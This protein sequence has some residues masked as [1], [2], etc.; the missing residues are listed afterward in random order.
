MIPATF[1][2][3]LGTRWDDVRQRPQHLLV[4]IA[5]AAT[6]IAVEPPLAS[7]EDHDDVRIDGAVTVI[8]PLR[9]C[10]GSLP[11]VDAQTVATARGYAGDGPAGVWLWTPLM[12]PLADAFAAPP[13]VYDTTDVLADEA[14]M[15]AAARAD[16]I[17]TA[18]RALLATYAGFGEKVR[19]EPDGVD[20]ERFAADVAPHPLP[21]ELR[22]PVFGYTGTIDER[23]D[24]GLIAALADAFPDGHVVMV[25]PV[26]S[27]ERSLLPRR[28][29]VHLTGAVSYDALPSWLAAF[30]VALIPFA[31]DRAA[32]APAELLE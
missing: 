3:G 25:G 19:C 20:F 27:R 6:V 11:H 21:G 1:V 17:F 23:I 32:A 14:G 13:L 8:R 5:D 2:A 10:A 24:A 9:R 15:R 7:A 29:N 18:G 31:R 26:A 16:L 30:D 12:L 4:R 28:P 22:G